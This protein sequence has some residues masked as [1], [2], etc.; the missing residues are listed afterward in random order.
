MYKEFCQLHAPTDVAGNLMGWAWHSLSSILPVL[1]VLWLKN[2]ANSLVKY[3]VLC[4][5]RIPTS[6][7]F[8]VTMLSCTTTKHTLCY[9][10]HS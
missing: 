3:R 2:I 4:Y 9:N 6:A 7:T 5:I 1:P 8:F 10:H